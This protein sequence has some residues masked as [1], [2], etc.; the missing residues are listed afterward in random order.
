[1]HYQH[2]KLVYMLRFLGNVPKRLSQTVTAI[3]MLFSNL[4]KEKALFFHKK[5]LPSSSRI[6]SYKYIT[7]NENCEL[8]HCFV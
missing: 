4:M 6:N 8:L 5:A 3:L 7:L 2:L 1:M